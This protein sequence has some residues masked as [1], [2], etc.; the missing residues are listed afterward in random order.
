MIIIETDRGIVII[1]KEIFFEH[2]SIYK[3]IENMLGRY[4]EYER[5]RRYC[6]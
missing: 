1:D 3:S 4:L 6:G 2:E 5:E